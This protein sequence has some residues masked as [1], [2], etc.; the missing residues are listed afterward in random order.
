MSKTFSLITN[1]HDSQ[2]LSP[3]YESEIIPF[4]HSGHFD[5]WLLFSKKDSLI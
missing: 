5:N 2:I 1:P 4:L 3:V